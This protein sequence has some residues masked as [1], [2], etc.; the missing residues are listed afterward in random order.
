[1]HRNF[2]INIRVIG[3]LK[4]RYLYRL[5]RSD[6]NAKLNEMKYS[7]VFGPFPLF[8]SLSP[9]ITINLYRIKAVESSLEKFALS[10]SP[11][12]VSLPL[13]PTFHAAKV[14]VFAV[15]SWS[16]FFLAWKEEGKGER[17]RSWTGNPYEF[18]GNKDSILNEVR[19]KSSVRDWIFHRSAWLCIKVGEKR[20]NVPSLPPPSVQRLKE[21]GHKWNRR[22]IS[23]PVKQRKREPPL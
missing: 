2:I 3:D 8:L 15:G 7:R 12:E 17:R 13:L 5:F 11:R 18:Y 22:N 1:M 10:P 23:L 9:P 20:W 16:N 6:L 19:C 14:F 4:D 21:T